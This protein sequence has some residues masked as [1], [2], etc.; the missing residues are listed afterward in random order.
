MSFA[1][2]CM[3][4]RRCSHLHSDPP[5]LSTPVNA[6]TQLG[7]EDSRYARE[8]FSVQGARVILDARQ[9]WQC[10]CTAFAADGRC[11]HVEQAQ[12]FRQMR[13]V[14]RE[15]DTIELQFSAAQMQGLSRAAEA[16]PTAA[17]APTRPVA[18][19]KRPRRHS[20]WKTVALAAAMSA[21]SSGITYVAATRAQASRA[22]EPQRLSQSLTPSPVPQYAPVR[23]VPVKFAN[24]FDATEV[25]EFPQETSQAEA[26]EAVA[27][28]LLNRARERQAADQIKLRSRN[29]ADSEKLQRALGGTEA[30]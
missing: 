9:G 16:E 21:I 14:Q 6:I 26:R 1:V 20:P 27:E 18:V 12:A 28:L 10:T 17:V 7:S 30:G 2:L 29:T 4:A 5:L 24:P 11:S 15:E 13:G 19:R 22:V 8:R 23:E 3:Q 25:F